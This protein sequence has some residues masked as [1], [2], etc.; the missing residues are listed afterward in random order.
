VDRCSTLALP[1][2]G[3]RDGIRVVLLATVEVSLLETHTSP[4]SQVD[5]R[6]DGE[7]T[8]TDPTHLRKF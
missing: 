8:Q 6:I 7:V 4:A 3:P 2:D 5:S 1:L